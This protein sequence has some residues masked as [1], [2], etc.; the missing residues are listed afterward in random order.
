M[1]VLT[2]TGSSSCYNI[3]LGLQEGGLDF[4]YQNSWGLT[5]RTIGV[6][7]MVHGDDAGLIL[8]PPVASVQVRQWA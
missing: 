3:V 1:Y 8:P 2:V 7:T 6:M 4:A 5:T